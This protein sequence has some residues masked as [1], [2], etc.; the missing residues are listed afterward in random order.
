MSDR[1][2]P[3]L[4]LA[5]LIEVFNARLG[6]ACA[7][8]TL[9]L[10]L[11]TAMVVVLRYGFG[12]GAVALQEA[13][14]Y[15]HA[16]VFMGAAAWVLQR[17]GHVRVDIFYR[18]LDRRRQTLVD[19]LGHLLFLLPLGLFIAWSSW[20]YVAN[21][22][23]TLERSSEAGGLRFVYLQKSFI[24]VL[25]GSLLLQGIADLIKAIWL[26]AGHPLPDTEGTDSSPRSSPPRD[27]MRDELADGRA[28][29]ATHG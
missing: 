18:K 20:E 12:I 16:L 17:N 26:L 21:A 2:P 1:L 10:V 11:G 27:R 4:R 23:S 6:R 8:L 25:A 28:P 7:W 15:A 3:P 29:E 13:V 19:L 22:W 24:L 14:L 5:R 9:F